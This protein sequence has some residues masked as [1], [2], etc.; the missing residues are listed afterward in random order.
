MC[1]C[2]ESIWCG[3]FFFTYLVNITGEVLI[4]LSVTYDKRAMG[5]P[6]YT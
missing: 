4:A 6:D 3:A 2:T 1:V 5:T